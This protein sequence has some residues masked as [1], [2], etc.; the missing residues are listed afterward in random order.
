MSDNLAIWTALEKTDPAHTKGFKRAGGFSGTATKPIYSIK[1]MTEQF[2]P[3]GIGWGNTKPEFQVVTAGDEI[4]VYCTAGLWHGVPT[5]V[6][7][8]VGGDK[9]SAKRNSG[10]NFNSD[11]AFKASFTDALSNAM[12]FL[13]VSADIH[14]GRFDDDKYVRELR[15]EFAG[16]SD[17]AQPERTDEQYVADAVAW[18]QKQ[19]DIATI[20]QAWASEQ[21]RF[22]ELPKPLQIELTTARDETL[23]RLAPRP[24]KSE[25]PLSADWEIK[26]KSIRSDIDAAIDTRT[27]R[28][29][30]EGRDFLDLEKHSKVTGSYLRNR[31]D[32][33]AGVIAQTSANQKA[34]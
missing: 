33:R 10:D 17:H 31:A 25:A 21:G 13:G 22:A 30:L 7:Y 34:A 24:G 8:G 29:I 3:I 12:K 5:N 11:E 15:G 28:D 2:G 27:I 6:F 16:K 9:V 1:R 32:K 4:L 19:G 14:M 20:N 26:A 18:M 23:A